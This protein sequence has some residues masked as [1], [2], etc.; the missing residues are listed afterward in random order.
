MD[1]WDWYLDINS[2]RS[3]GRSTDGI[4]NGVNYFYGGTAICYKDLWKK[5]ASYA[6]NNDCQLPKSFSHLPFLPNIDENDVIKQEDHNNLDGNG[7]PI[8][9]TKNVPGTKILFLRIFSLDT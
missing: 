6:Y 8:I 1:S 4:Y 5:S 7:N 9:V 2:N 3:D